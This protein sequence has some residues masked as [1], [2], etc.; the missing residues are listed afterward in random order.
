MM[1]GP[2]LISAAGKGLPDSSFITTARRRRALQSA[3]TGTN[4]FDIGIL[5]DLWGDFLS[6]PCSFSYLKSEIPHLR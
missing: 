3:Q 6:C 4:V 1:T 2:E 5:H